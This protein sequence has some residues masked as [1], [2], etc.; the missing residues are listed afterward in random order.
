MKKFI[1]IMEKDIQKDG[2]TKKEVLIYGVLV[3]ISLVAIMA[4]A[5]WL[6][7]ICV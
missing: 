7:T 4:I 3:P 6:E 5:G 1:N 2:F